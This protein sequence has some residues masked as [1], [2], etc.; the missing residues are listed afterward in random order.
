MK[1]YLFIYGSTVTKYRPLHLWF[2]LIRAFSFCGCSLK[3]AILAKTKKCLL[4]GSSC[5]A[6]L[7][8]HGCFPHQFKTSLGLHETW[9]PSWM[10]NSGLCCCLN[11]WVEHAYGLNILFAV[12]YAMLF[13][14]HHLWAV[15]FRRSFTGLLWWV[16]WGCISMS[17]F[18]IFT[19]F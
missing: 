13:E 3:L 11:A 9:E 1:E 8:N 7:S 19:H 15:T 14:Q 12:S 18:L 10:E 2:S 16:N 17:N 5:P 6:P 4:E